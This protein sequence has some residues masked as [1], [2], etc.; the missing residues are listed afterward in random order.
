M[1]SLPMLMQ[2]SRLASPCEIHRVA[3]LRL[4]IFKGGVVFENKEREESCF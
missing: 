2:R 1:A 3:A 4:A